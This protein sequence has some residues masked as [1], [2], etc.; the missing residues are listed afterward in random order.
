M[1]P[2]I[3]YVS[4]ETTPLFPEN[5]GEKAI[6]HLLWGDRVKLKTTSENAGDLVKISA[7]GRVGFVKNTHLSNEPLL[8]LYF[9]DVGQGDGILIKTPDEKHIM[10]DGGYKRASQQS[11][12][13][14]AD[15]V[16]W[17]FKKDYGMN[18]IE[19]DA[20][21]ASHNDADHYGGL[22][23]LINPKQQHELDIATA[24]VNVTRFYHAGV[25]WFKKGTSRNLGPTKGKK[26]TLLVDDLDDITELMEPGRDG[27][28][29]QGEWAK[30][31]QC[32]I[33]KQI[34]SQR[35]SNKTGSLDQ[36]TSDEFKI[37]VLAPLETEHDGKPAYESLGG[38]SQNTNGHSITLRL[39]YKSVKILLTGDLNSASQKRILSFYENNESELA[40][41]VA[42]SCHHGSDDCSF[43]FLTHV[44]AGASVISSGD[45]EGHCHPR[46]SIVAA[47]GITGHKTILDDKI[48]TPLIY[49]TEISRSY[50]L[51]KI[52]QLKIKETGEILESNTR[53]DVTYK[54]TNAGDLNPATKTRSF[55]DKKIV[56]GII[57]GLVNVR[58][59]GKKILC[60]TMSE[61]GNGWDIKTFNSRF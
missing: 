36:F 24:N 47:S 23:D 34:P 35:I 52:E 57:Y 27:Y 46:P 53:I 19:L 15:F 20:M 50:K 29:L 21:I 56:G 28:K 32:I 7:R 9:I 55:W 30:F 41:D 17:K 6:A 54:E 61:S 18:S 31:M 48:I 25:A 14:A 1:A 8:E 2:S 44:S 22:W 13:N 45:A 16:D 59:D 26:L 11:G 60:A 39:D 37:N 12:K 4:E 49:S 58:T 43:E 42:K 33:D 10:I 40:C 3:K 38:S 51:G 5:N